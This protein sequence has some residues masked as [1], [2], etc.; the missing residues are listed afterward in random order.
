MKKVVSFTVDNVLYM[1]E[2]KF[3]VASLSCHRF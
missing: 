3:L 2:R 1:R